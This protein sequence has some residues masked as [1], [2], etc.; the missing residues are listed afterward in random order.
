[1]K[2]PRCGT[3]NCD[4]LLEDP[5]LLARIVGKKLALLS[6]REARS[7]STPKKDISFFGV[8]R[9][10]ASRPERRASFFPT[11]RARRR[12]S[13]RRQSQLVVPQRGHFMVVPVTH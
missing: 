2:C 8:D 11:I 4:C 9:L 3:T 13:S 1:M 7:L 6:G 5:R 12:G 10:R